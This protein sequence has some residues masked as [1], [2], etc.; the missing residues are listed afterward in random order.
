MKKFLSGVIIASLCATWALAQEKPPV[1]VELHSYQQVVVKDKNGKV[2]KDKAGK[3]LKKWVKASRVVP[4]TVVKYVDT[5]INE[6]NT[7]IE[8][9]KVKNMIDPN[10][11]FIADSA[12]SEAKFDVKYSIDGGKHFDLPEKLFVVEKKKKRLAK[13]SEY[14][15]IMFVVSK[16]PAHSKVEVSYKTKLK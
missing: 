12:T 7:T 13:P 11:A 4:E 3:P 6:T 14:N 1:R 15:A 5:I 8:D 2:K 10:L 9:A 16:V